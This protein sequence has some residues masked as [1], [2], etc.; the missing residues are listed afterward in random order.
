M[1][2]VQMIVVDLVAKI[3]LKNELFAIKLFSLVH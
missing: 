3:V 1:I 2:M